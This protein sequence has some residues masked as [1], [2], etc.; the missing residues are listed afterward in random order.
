MNGQRHSHSPKQACELSNEVDTR[1]A[2]LA[3]T[4]DATKRLDMSRAAVATGRSAMALTPPDDLHFSLHLSK[5][6]RA[7]IAEYE[8]TAEPKLLDEAIMLA[9]QAVAAKPT[10]SA[11]V[12]AHMSL[13]QALHARYQRTS[14]VAALIDAV[15]GCRAAETACKPGDRN[16][17]AVQSHRCFL[18]VKLLK[19][20]PGDRPLL[21]DTV[22]LARNILAEPPDETRHWL[23]LM[24][25]LVTHS[26]TLLDTDADRGHLDVAAVAVGEAIRLAGALLPEEP[27]C[28]ELLGE[29]GST[30]GLVG[31]IR[32]DANLLAQAVEV[33][34]A[35]L[36]GWCRTGPG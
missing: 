9:E 36:G 33:T 13:A 24:L 12:S 23:S 18:Q 3:D 25:E 16:L 1:L 26:Q 22:Q 4:T 10:G 19:H 34:R 35:A 8:Q 20:V 32:Q 11:A 7:L 21:A 28:A 6:V 17:R 29:L 5:L 14:D 2:G 31:E 30:L 15:A 27:R